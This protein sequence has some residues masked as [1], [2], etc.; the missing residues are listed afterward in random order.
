MIDIADDEL[1]LPG[2]TAHI[3]ALLPHDIRQ[4]CSSR[5]FPLGAG[6]MHS[7]QTRLLSPLHLLHYL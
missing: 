4:E 6:D 1:R 7:L 3:V 5:T 2:I